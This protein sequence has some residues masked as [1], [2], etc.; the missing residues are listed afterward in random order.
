MEWK[1]S[2]MSTDPVRLK[3]QSPYF[4][5]VLSIVSIPLSTI[6]GGSIGKGILIL[7]LALAI[8]WAKDLSLGWYV[9]SAVGAGM[10]CLLLIFRMDL[11]ARDKPLVAAMLPLS[12]AVFTQEGPMF[13]DTGSVFSHSPVGIQLN[14]RAKADLNGTRIIHTQTGIAADDDAQLKT[15]N[16]TIDG[17]PV[18]QPR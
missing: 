13:K 7:A 14:G 17:S 3:I 10:I 5:P 1:V 15:N 12:A 18:D 11:V 6:A 8:W 2:P 9:V 4:G 16:V